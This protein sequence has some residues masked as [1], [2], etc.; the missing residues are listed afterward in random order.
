MHRARSLLVV[1]LAAFAVAT[2]GLAL[3]VASADPGS[4]VAP[5]APASVTATAG[6]GE[7]AVSWTWPADNGSPLTEYSVTAMAQAPAS[8]S[9]MYEDIPVPPG[10]TAGDTMTKTFHH[11]TNGSTYRIYIAV[12]NGTGQS[13]FA[14]S[15]EFTPR[16]APYTPRGVTAN[17]GNRSI[18]ATW[19]PGNNGGSPLSGYT[20]T[21]TPP[22]GAPALT[23]T[24]APDVT[25]A[26]FS[27]LTNGT[28]YALSVVATNE[29]GTGPAA[30]TTA[31]PATVPGAATGVTATRGDLRAIVR[32]KVPPSNGSPITG[33]RV[34]ASPGD[35]TMEVPYST[36]VRLFDGLSNGSRYTFKVV[37]INAKGAGPASAPSAAVVPAGPPWQTATPAVAAGKRF[38]TVSWRAPFRNGSAITRF[39]V[40][41]S[42]G[43]TKAVTGSTRSL[44]FAGL[45]KGKRLSFRVRA[46]TAAGTGAYSAAS[47]VVT[48]K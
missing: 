26:S 28:S 19:L 6:T 25:S 31:T 10:V 32:W 21:L 9:Y 13:E 36:D 37:A 43:V 40:R 41:C 48:I 12:S 2:P 4:P 33:Y 30:T 24:V 16:G 1:L 42:N 39:Q 27:G 47:A 22:G 23:W 15:D 11:I 7:V 3:P 35:L 5:D 44:K 20:A 34:I 38:A 14:I 45:R 8:T 29:Y 17:T 46:V 18:V